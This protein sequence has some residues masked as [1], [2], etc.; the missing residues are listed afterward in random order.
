M[1]RPQLL[2]WL[3]LLAD[4]TDYNLIKKDL[5]QLGLKYQLADMNIYCK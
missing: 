4:Y 2:L 5:F 3:E 1:P